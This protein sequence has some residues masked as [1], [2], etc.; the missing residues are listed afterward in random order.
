MTTTFRASSVWPVL[1]NAAKRSKRSAHVAVAYFGQGA[2]KLLPIGRE[3]RLVVDASESTVKNGLTC[4]DELKKLANRGVRVFSV[5][6]LHAKVFVLGSRVFV[7]S[8][9]VSRRSAGTLVEAMIVTSDRT[10][11]VEAKRFVDSLCR[12]EL[13]PEAIDRLA[14]MY[15]PPRIEGLSRTRLK[16]GQ[17]QVPLSLP[18]V[19]LA[20]LIH[21]DPPDGSEEAME[22][23][24]VKAKSLMA[25][26]RRHEL[27]EFWWIGNCPIRKHD[28]VVQVTKETNGRRMV[29]PPGTVV[30]LAKC[31][32]RGSRVTF[33]YVEVPVKRRMSLERLARQ[34]GDGAQKKLRRGGKVNRQFAERLLAVWSDGG[35]R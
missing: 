31:R 35:G 5:P 34:M 9:N 4:P 2:S 10:A 23:G 12:H 32:S 28:V 26:P 20:Q 11:V 18:R 17:R 25:H 27:E 29:S 3:S 7:G 24:R 19:L 1:R 22:K 8:S 30:D 15:R 16:T 13:G 33:V 6:N 14:K 21:E